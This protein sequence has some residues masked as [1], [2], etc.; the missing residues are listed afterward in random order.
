[1][2]AVYLDSLGKFRRRRPRKEEREESG[3]GNWM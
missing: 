2:L 3:R 1:M